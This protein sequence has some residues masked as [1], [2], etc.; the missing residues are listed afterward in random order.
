MRFA[1]FIAAAGIAFAM[2][3]TA[4]TV[5]PGASAGSQTDGLNGANVTAN[6]ALL[7]GFTV[8]DAFG[9]VTSNPPYAESLLGGNVI[10][11]DGA[12]LNFIDFNTTAPTTF[13]GFNI[14]V[15][16]DGPPNVTDRQFA[17][18]ELFAGTAANALTSLGQAT[19]TPGAFTVNYSFAPTAYQYFR[20]EGTNFTNGARLL[21]IDGIGVPEPSTWALMIM[22]F[23]L[24][25][26]GMRSA[27]RRGTLATA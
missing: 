17:T 23:G 27:R 25:G 16:S 8:A 24:V 9:S 2:P 10:F 26:A 21:E 14:F 15:S 22:G 20:F 19:L 12:N 4:Q 13:T 1:N 6:S 5:I 7:Q 18:V 3:A 11:A